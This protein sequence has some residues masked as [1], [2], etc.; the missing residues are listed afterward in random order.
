MQTPRKGRPEATKARN[1]S[2]RPR[3]RSFAICVRGGAHAG[4]DHAVGTGE[5]GGV[6]GDHRFELGVRER[7]LD[8]AEVA[9]VVI[10][11]HEIGI[12]LHRISVRGRLAFATG[13][14][15]RSG[16]RTSSSLA[17]LSPV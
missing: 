17:T 14:G 10:D 6:G 15:L 16:W 4:Q 13:L 2:T 3:S 12:G 9:G 7:A 1:G 8:A 11:D 5:V